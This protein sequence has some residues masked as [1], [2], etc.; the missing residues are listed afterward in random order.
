MLTMSG[1]VVLNAAIGITK[2]RLSQ[3][4]IDD[5]FQV[6]MLAQLHL[7]QTLL[8]R[9]EATALAQGTPARWVFMSS[10][11]HHYT[12]KQTRFETLAELNQDLGTEAHYYRSKLAQILIVRQ[13]ALRAGAMSNTNNGQARKAVD[14]PHCVGKEA[15]V[16]EEEVVAPA[17]VDVRVLVNAT[18][19]GDY[20]R[21]A[22][23]DNLRV[24][25]GFLGWLLLLILGPF[26]SDPMTEGCHSALFA[27]TPN[28][29]LLRRLP[30][31]QYIVPSK[32]IIEPS[33]RGRDDAGLGE[34]V[35]RLSMELLDKKLR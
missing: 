21:T 12:P 31:G 23:T 5:H 24:T 30:N 17:H 14:H 4:G 13:L 26:M 27:C 11:T 18:H 8:P 2:S 15:F 3:D 22:L 25:F 32:R 1:Q 34:N 16:V 19:P 28:A 10:A 35:W 29:D 20:N 33:P 6:N 7:G 9:M